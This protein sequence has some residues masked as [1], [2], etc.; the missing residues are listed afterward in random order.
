MN[1]KIR[2]SMIMLIAATLFFVSSLFHASTASAGIIMKFSDI[3]KQDAAYSA[4]LYI[5]SLEYMN[6]YKDAK[7]KPK[8]AVTKADAAKFVGKA[9]EISTAKT[10]VAT[11]FEDVTEK[12]ANYSYIT[13]L[14]AI[15][16]FTNSSKFN[17]D[18]TITRQEA[19]KLFVNAFSLPMKTSKEYADVS[20][21]NAYSDYISTAASYNILKGN[22]A[23]NFLPTKKMNRAD[24]AVALKKAIDAKE[25]INNTFLEETDGDS[26]SPDSNLDETIDEEE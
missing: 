18:K 23:K 20:A 5:T 13:A 22:S 4:V 21:K 7:F 16:A 10:S 26:N 25:E 19:A 24:F 1:H 15:D 2:N 17:P 6:V 8:K 3:N 12:T 14:T 11:N 9:C